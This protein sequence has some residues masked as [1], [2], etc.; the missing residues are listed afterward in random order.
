MADDINE[1]LRQL[2]S[3]PD[4]LS[5]VSSVLSKLNSDDSKH[6]DIEENNLENTIKN[7]VS[8][9]SSDGDRRINLLSALKPYMRQTRA[10]NIDK[11]IKMLKLT[12]LSSVFKDL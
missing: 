12:K 9:F 3:N 2:L 6:A 8:S 11:A 5:M 1:K 7:A 10:D 4:A